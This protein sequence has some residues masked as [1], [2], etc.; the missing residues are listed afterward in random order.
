MAAIRL[1]SIIWTMVGAVVAAFLSLI[2]TVILFPFWGWFESVTGIESLGHSGPAT[3]CFLLMAGFAVAAFLTVRI[4][5][6]VS[7]RDGDQSKTP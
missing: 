5:I 4:I 1:T 3:W 7:K 2:L 6:C